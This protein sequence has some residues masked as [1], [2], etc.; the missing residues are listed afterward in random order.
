MKRILGIDPGTRLAGYGIVELGV[1]KLEPRLVEGGVIRLDTKVSVTK[2]LVQLYDDVCGI[3]DEFEP[4]FLAIEKLFA[5]YKH[6]RTAIL[7]AHARGV[8][9]LAAEQRG[10]EVIN[11]GANEVKKNITGHGHASKEQMQRAVQSIYRLKELPT[12]EDVADAI[13][14]ATTAGRRMAVHDLV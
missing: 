10:M 9:L 4:G 14:I 7:M 13:G 6:P 1:G 11:L 5:H 8:V 2:R 12:P 3:M